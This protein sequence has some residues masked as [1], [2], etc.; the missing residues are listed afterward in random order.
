MDDGGALYVKPD[1]MW[2]DLL[3]TTNGER[4][5]CVLSVSENG[6]FASCREYLR[7]KATGRVTMVAASHLTAESTLYRHE[8]GATIPPAEFVKRVRRF[9][10]HRS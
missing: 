8:P 9:P 1:Q 5:L 2:R 3:A 10:R 4:T 7:G 6:R